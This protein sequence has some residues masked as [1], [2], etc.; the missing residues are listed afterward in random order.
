[1]AGKQLTLIRKT[2]PSPGQNYIL[3][4]SLDLSDIYDP[5]L[6][7]PGLSVSVGRNKTRL[8][9]QA[10]YN[11]EGYRLNDKQVTQLTIF[12]ELKPNSTNHKGVVF[13]LKLLSMF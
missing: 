5:P 10:I 11:K 4:A 9:N 13:S 7:L 6:L 12:E 1:M 2:K 8:T 3:S